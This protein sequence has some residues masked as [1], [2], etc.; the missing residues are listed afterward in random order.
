MPNK[1]ALQRSS[2]IGICHLQFTFCRS[3][4]IA[5]RLP[6]IV[7]VIYLP[8]PVNLLPFFVSIHRLQFIVYRLSCVIYHFPITIYHFLTAY[9]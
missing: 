5:H 9:E 7:A 2:S 3:E 8:S 6:I 4:F 1:L